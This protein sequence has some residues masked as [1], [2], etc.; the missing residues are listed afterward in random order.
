MSHPLPSGHKPFTV[1]DCLLYKQQG[2]KIV[3]VTSYDYPTS[4][5]LDEAG[6]HVQLVGDSLGMVVQGHGHSLTV[7]LEHMIYHS[8]MVSRAAKKSLVV[9][10]MPFMTYQKSPKQALENAGRLVQEGGAHAVKLEGGERSTAAIE[11]IVQADIPV[12]GHIGLT[13]QSLHRMGGFRV[14]RDEAQLLRDAQAVADSGAFSIVIEG[15]PSSLAASIT[16]KL[17]IPTIGIGAGPQCDGQVLV[18][19][20][21]FEYGLGRRPKFVKSY[22]HLNQL[23]QEGTKA[24]LEEVQGGQFPGP[25]HQYS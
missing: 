13:P 15:V 5:I 6:V 25:E 23:I 10:D 1:P 20:D 24:F 2:K 17:A 19:H 21:L 22:A 3:V 8:E 18:F 4:Q 11:K 9:T 16:R 12:M 7:T 14:Q